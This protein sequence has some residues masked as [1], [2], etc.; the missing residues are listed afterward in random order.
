[1]HSGR[2]GERLE[3]FFFHVCEQVSLSRCLPSVA[4]AEAEPFVDGFSRNAR[5][6]PFRSVAALITRRASPTLFLPILACS[7]APSCSSAAGGVEFFPFP[8]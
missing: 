1:M 8:F 5:F 4:V 6:R 7:T 3:S 2:D